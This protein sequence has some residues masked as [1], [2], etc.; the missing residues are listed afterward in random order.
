VPSLADDDGKGL[1]RS[2]PQGRLIECQ[3]KNPAGP[4]GSRG[5]LGAAQ[6]SDLFR[7]RDVSYKLRDALEATHAAEIVQIRARGSPYRH[8]FLDCADGC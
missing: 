4:N 5:G 1:A 8:R 2:A 6:F 3:R 7:Q